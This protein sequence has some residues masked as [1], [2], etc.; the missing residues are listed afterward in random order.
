[1]GSKNG[2]RSRE[3]SSRDISLG[4]CFA[5]KISVFKER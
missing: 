3:M 1:M 2:K 5:Q 4:E